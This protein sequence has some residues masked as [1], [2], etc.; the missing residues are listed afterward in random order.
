VLAEKKK[1]TEAEQK[2][3]GAILKAARTELEFAEALGYGK[4]GDFKPFYEQLDKIAEKTKGGKYG[5]GFFD[6][7]K[8]ALAE[9]RARLF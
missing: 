9:F 6:E 3:L 7:L 8:K 2:E 5:K 4:E 1:R